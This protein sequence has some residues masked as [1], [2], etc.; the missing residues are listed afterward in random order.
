M[1]GTMK[2]IPCSCGENQ[3]EVIKPEDN[4]RIGW[5]CPTCNGFTKSVGRERVWIADR[6]TTCHNGDHERDKNK[7]TLSQLQGAETR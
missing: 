3:E 2:T 1:N 4:L 7:E 5:W 6:A